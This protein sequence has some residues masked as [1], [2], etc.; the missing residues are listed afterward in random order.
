MESQSTLSPKPATMS[1]SQTLF[2]QVATRA[3]TDPFKKYLSSMLSGH[4]PIVETKCPS[5]TSSAPQQP[6]EDRDLRC[7]Q[8]DP[9][10]ET[11]QQCIQQ[12]EHSSGEK[13]H[14]I[15]EK[16]RGADARSTSA[17]PSDVKLTDTAGLLEA[18][19][20]DMRQRDCRRDGQRVHTQPTFLEFG[21][22]KESLQHITE[23]DDFVATKDRTRHEDK[24]T[25]DTDVLVK[26]NPAMYCVEGRGK[27]S[28]GHKVNELTECERHEGDSRMHRSEDSSRER[29]GSSVVNQSLPHNGQVG[30]RFDTR[31]SDRGRR[32][33]A[34]PAAFRDSCRKIKRVEKSKLWL[35]PRRRGAV[36][37]P[38]TKPDIQVDPMPLWKKQ[39]PFLYGL[40]ACQ[41]HP[42]NP[43]AIQWCSGFAM[44]RGSLLQRLIMSI[45]GKSDEARHPLVL[46]AVRL[47]WDE[48]RFGALHDLFD[49][50]SLDVSTVDS[51][52]LQLSARVQVTHMVHVTEPVR[53]IEHSP[54]HQHLFASQSAAGKVLVHDLSTWHGAGRE[55][56]A[57]K[58]PYQPAQNLAHACAPSTTQAARGLAWSPC[59]H[60]RL[61]SASHQG[62]VALWDLDRGALLASFVREEGEV[63][64]DLSFSKR[65]PSL[66]VSCFMDGSVCLWDVRRSGEGPVAGIRASD[67]NAACAQIGCCGSNELVAVGHTEGGAKLWDPRH[68]KHCLHHL[69]WTAGGATSSVSWA[70]TVPGAVATTDSLGHVVLWDLSRIGDRQTE[71]EAQDGPPELVFVHGGHISATV[72]G[73]TWSKDAPWLIATAAHSRP[74]S[75]GDQQGEL[76]L[77]RPADGLLS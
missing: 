31:C 13:V 55:D 23:R 43:I 1:V 22:R 58:G 46:C 15:A 5:S 45:H 28:P 61:I 76:Q 21:E 36:R 7:Q 64:T 32:R 71:I 47:P 18:G 4:R 2:Q 56:A 26:E 74:R 33:I 60:S 12:Y 30:G 48:S 68:L 69:A 77:W 73:A 54:F 41:S 34:S 72:T 3:S 19:A 20:M 53:Q 70:P 10:P 25:S 67:A 9:V 14:E 52:K 6:Q 44:S 40:L 39:A 16:V 49:R 27:H 35:A 42:F 66:F 62:T 57:T 59:E 29:G 37:P 75:D 24:R 63:V 38:L 17:K 11:A 8:A 51:L 65:E 50:G